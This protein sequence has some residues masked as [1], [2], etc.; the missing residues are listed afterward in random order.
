MAHE[1]R[2][3]L[4]QEARGQPAP[5]VLVAASLVSAASAIAGLNLWVAVVAGM[6]TV[7]SGVQVMGPHVLVPVRLNTAQRAAVPVTEQG[8]SSPL[9]G[10]AVQ[11]KPGRWLTAAHVVNDAGS[12]VQ[13]RL[14]AGWAEAKVIF[15]HETA[16]L[17]VLECSSAHPWTASL[18]LDMPEEGDAVR[19]AGWT[20]RFDHR[21]LRLSLDYVAQSETDRQEL[22]VTGPNPQWGFGGAPAIEMRSGKIFGI[23][24]LFNEDRNHVGEGP[25]PLQESYIACIRQLSNG[26]L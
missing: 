8:K 19:V 25:R 2:R 22:M 17:A 21:M 26:V 20:S 3:Q 12:I 10:T 6:T 18:M 11:Y 7:V 16:D 14:D 23:Y 24:S 5:L 15:R 1:Q 9:C 13:L 4:L